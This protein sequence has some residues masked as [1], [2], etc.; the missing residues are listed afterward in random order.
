MRSACVSKTD[1]LDRRADEFIAVEERS[2]EEQELAEAETIT[3]DGSSEGLAPI[4]V[5]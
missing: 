5:A 3:F 1:L 2:I 4:L